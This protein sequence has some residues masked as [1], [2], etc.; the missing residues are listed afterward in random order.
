MN[1]L[2][3]SEKI[4][5]KLVPEPNQTVR[6]RMTQ[7][8]EVDMSFE[9]E[10]P[11]AEALPGPMKIASKTVFAITQKVGAQDKEGN[12]TAEMTYDEIISEMTMNGQPMQLGDATGKFTGKKVITTFNKQGEVIVLKMPP[13]LGLA[14]DT[15]KQ[16]L[17]SFYGGL[18][19]TPIGVGEVAMTPLD[20]SV[21]IPVPGATPVKM[22]GQVKFKLVSVEK[23]EAGRIANFDQTLDGK[24]ASNTDF[25]L[26][27]GKVR[28]N[29]D[30]KMNGAGV[31][32]MNV[33]KGVVKSSDVKATF[34]G[35]LKM[36]G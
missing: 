10:A 28:M 29:I 18:P 22:D 21:P 15:F 33:D 31:L 8:M 25:P 34:G 16:I 11:S 1:A 3:Q 4:I 24:I 9:G 13:D 30:I 19:P 27:N 35:R 7:V 23:E 14:E 2:A 20:F 6:M 32:V 5:F 26:P 36:S 17:K 12:V